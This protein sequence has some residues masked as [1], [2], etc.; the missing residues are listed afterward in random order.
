MS[1]NSTGAAGSIAEGSSSKY[2]IERKG[3]I[4][5]GASVLFV[6]LLVVTLIFMVC[7]R[8]LATFTTD[9]ISFGSFITGTTWNPHQTGDDGQPLMGA[10]PMIAG[11]FA[12]T[13]LSCVLALPFALGA[14]IFVVE[15]QPGFGSKVFRP[16]I[17][18]LTGIPSVVFGLVGL[19]I[20]VPWVRSW[21]GGTGY[22]IMAGSIVLAFMILPTVTSLS[23]DAL[24]AV[25]EAYRDGSYGLG[26][27]R[28]QTILHV[29]I[30]SALPGILTAVIMGMARAFGEALAVQMVVGNAAQMPQGLFMPAA[31]L[32][33]VLTM[34][35]GNEA[36][37]TVYN[38]VLWSLALVLLVMSLFFILIVHLIGRKG[39]AKN[40]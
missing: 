8:G 32:T 27:T 33:S 36:M 28:W 4:L 39:A 25:P 31:T 9:G 26:C 1:T 3:K 7:S 17:E 13:L 12:V 19:S 22:G 2:R 29:V 20:I 40:D 18:L 16:M 24:A 15:I 5:T 34:G 21:A 23:T 35:M 11:S 10:L 14:A 38:D 30:P 6:V 37:G